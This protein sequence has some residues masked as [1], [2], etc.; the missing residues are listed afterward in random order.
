MA[1]NL[2]HFPVRSH[3]VSLRSLAKGIAMTACLF[4]CSV[5]FNGCMVDFSNPLP[6]ARR[7][8]ANPRLL[9]RWAGKDEQGNT[10]FIQFDTAARN[11]ITVSIFGENSNLGYQNPVFKLKTAKIGGFDYLVLRPNDSG[12]VA[13]YTLARYYVDDGK[14]KIWALSLDKVREAVKN[15]QLKGRATGG[16]YGGVV[17]TSASKDIVRFINRPESNAFFTYLGEFQKVNK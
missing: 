6:G 4:G 11:E 1:K 14:L 16:P 13:D 15:G 5:F 9:G 17:V 3:H 12:A 8:N 7:F 10:G 2:R